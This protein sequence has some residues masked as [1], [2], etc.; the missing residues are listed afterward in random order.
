[1]PEKPTIEKSNIDQNSLTLL[2]RNIRLFSVALL[3]IMPALLVWC[4]LDPH[5]FPIGAHDTVLGLWPEGP[6]PLSKKI[7]GFLITM[8]PTGALLLAITGIYRLAGQFGAGRFI[9]GDAIRALKLASSGFI[10]Y[11]LLNIAHQ[12]MLSVWL[13][14]DRPQGERMLAVGIEGDDAVMLLVGLLMLALTR[15]FVVERERAEDHAS[16]I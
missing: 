4:W 11:A 2:S 7:G 16:I 14:Y 9:S 1:M 8:L 6:M 10:G 3:I 13:T 5:A 15:V 12:A